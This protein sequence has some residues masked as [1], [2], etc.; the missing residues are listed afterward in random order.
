MN[1]FLSHFFGRLLLIKCFELPSFFFPFCYFCFSNEMMA[2]LA[3]AENFFLHW[4]EKRLPW[5]LIEYTGM[6]TVVYNIKCTW[7]KGYHIVHTHTHKHKFQTLCESVYYVSDAI[8]LFTRWSPSM[9][10]TVSECTR[11]AKWRKSNYLHMQNII[12]CAW[13][14]CHDWINKMYSDASEV[15]RQPMH[16]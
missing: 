4:I 15:H 13:E 14:V 7:Q 9:S 2:R 11:E 8:F 1:H 5:L 6:D 10:G 3:A 12:H 16:M